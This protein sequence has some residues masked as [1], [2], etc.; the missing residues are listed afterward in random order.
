MNKH[1]RIQSMIKPT[2]NNNIQKIFEL[3]PNCVTETK[4]KNGTRKVIDIDKLRQELS[5][6]AIDGPKERYGLN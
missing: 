3:F 4:D 1:E 5:E 6:S 2:L